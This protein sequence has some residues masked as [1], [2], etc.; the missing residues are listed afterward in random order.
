MV[1]MRSTAS[2][3][4][5]FAA[6]LQFVFHFCLASGRSDL[7]MIG[8]SL[9]NA[10]DLQE[11]VRQ[12]LD[13]N[14]AYDSVYA[15]RFRKPGSKFSEDVNDDTIL[16]TVNE[17]AWSWVVLQ[18]QSQIPGFYNASFGDVSFDYK[19]TFKQSIQAAA[20]MDGWI[21]EVGASTIL[22]MTWGFLKHD[23]LNQELYPD[24]LTMQSR[25]A[26]GY[27]IIQKELSTV[28]R[29]VRVAPAGLAYKSVYDSVTKGDPTTPDTAFSDLYASD[30]KHPSK[31]GSYLAACTL[32][33]T[34]TGGDPRRLAYKPVGISTAQQT[35]LQNRAAETVQKYNWDNTYNLQFFAKEAA[36]PRLPAEKEYA[37]EDTTRPVWGVRFAALAALVLLGFWLQRRSRKA[38]KT[39]RV[40]YT[41]VL[42]DSSDFTTGTDDLDLDIT[43]ANAEE[44]TTVSA[45]P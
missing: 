45:G 13:E 26:S 9:T 41:E 3:F 16:S 5:V 18:E 20:T 21:R 4:L 39:R 7:L 17:R 10:N 36:D 31:Q 11:M 24:Y 12:M 29:P 34:I 27:E 23:P 15:L 40:K 44:Y 6:A 14:I 33:G 25:I 1:K 35:F 28:D 22:F 8:N 43:P 37:T 32:Y 30:G 38:N 42:F 19:G 2:K